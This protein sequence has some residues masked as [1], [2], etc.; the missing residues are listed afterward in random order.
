MICSSVGDSSF[1]CICVI[2]KNLQAED[3]KRGASK[4]SELP[5][6][7]PQNEGGGS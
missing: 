5:N 3:F 4:F 2:R 1:V 7:R 6:S